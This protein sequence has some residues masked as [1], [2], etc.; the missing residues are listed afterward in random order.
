MV[1]K[2]FHSWRIK[3]GIVVFVSFIF[4]L[5][6]FWPQPNYTEGFKNLYELKEYAKS[7]DEWIK[8]D[9]Q[10]I[11]NPS[12]ETYYQ[13]KFS[14]SLPRL[15]FSKIESF[16]VRLHIMKRPYF[17]LSFFRSILK[18]VGQNRV[19]RSWQGDFVQKIVIE[20]TSK[21]VVFGAVQG[22]FHSLVRY[23]EQLVNLDIIDEDLKIKNSD[24]YMIFL[25]N[26][27]NRSAYNLEI[28]S[29]I[30]RLLQNN[31]EN[32]IYLKGPNEF[33]EYW[34]E[35][36]LYREMELGFKDLSKCVE[37]AKSFFDTLPLTLFGKISYFDS[38]IDDYIKFEPSLRNQELQKKL[39]IG[40]LLNPFIRQML[41]HRID[42]LSLDKEFKREILEQLISPRAVVQDIRKKYSYQKMNGLRLLDIKNGTSI[43]TVLSTA[44]EPY[45]VFFDFNFD[46]L[47]VIYPSTDLKNWKISLYN[48]DIK[49]KVVAFGSHSFNFFTGEEIKN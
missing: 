18:D 14:K 27:V 11:A 15:F 2:L 29:I 25:G 37:E 12:Y 4:L 6:F 47:A 21:I 39:E 35:H 5:G 42:M 20:P 26:A 38:R 36:T 33:Y 40:S 49:D 45:R 30:L 24:Y 10:N 34:R 8:M 43:W 28:L 7:I 48:R 32:V 13:N 22:A 17:S 23:M 44:A 46:A 9:N 16:L 41:E 19:R 31:P 1:G 3:A